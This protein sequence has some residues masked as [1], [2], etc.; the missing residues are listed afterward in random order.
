M[1]IAELG[2]DM[3]RLATVGHLRSWAGRCPQLTESAGKVMSRRLRYGA[4][5][6]KTVVVQCA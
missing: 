6:L 3:S 5:W 4:P 2:L 1:I